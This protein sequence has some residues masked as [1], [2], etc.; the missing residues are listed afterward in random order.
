MEK[1]KIGL[2]S[3]SD[4]ESTSSTRSSNS[5]SSSSSWKHKQGRSQSSTSED[6][7][8][9]QWKDDHDDNKT[10]AFRLQAHLNAPEAQL[11]L[12]LLIAFD[13]CGT[14]IEI[15]LRNLQQ[16]KPIDP[17][18]GIVASL[19]VQVLTRLLESFTGFTLFLFVS[20]LAI[21]LAAFRLRFFSQTGYVLDFAIV[22]TSA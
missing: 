10:L 9:K 7:A 6:F 21:L 14:A 1:L 13:I 4:A 5:D 8:K 22:S 18:S 16:L 12:I 11:I 2:T 19:L 3:A 20:E 15:H 17:S